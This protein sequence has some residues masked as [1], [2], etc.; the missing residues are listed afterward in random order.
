MRLNLKVFRI[1]KQLSQGEIS[2]KLGCTR[3]TYAAIEAGARSGKQEFWK[4]LQEEFRVPDSEMWKMMR[5]D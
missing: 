4:K 5:N 2:A 3:A 1:K